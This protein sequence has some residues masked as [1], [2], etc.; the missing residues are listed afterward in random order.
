MQSRICHSRCMSR[1][2]VLC[3]GVASFEPA[4]PAAVHGDHVFV[5][6]FLQ[7]VGG[8]SRPESPA[9]VEHNGCRSVRNTLLYV[10][11]DDSF[12]EI[13]CSGHMP[14]SPFALFTHVHKRDF[15]AGVQT[16]LSFLDV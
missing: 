13:N 8:E 16:L 11:L 1:D 7:V 12:A 2:L 4:F 3:G 9:A 10:A 6:H 5:T 14:A 15:L